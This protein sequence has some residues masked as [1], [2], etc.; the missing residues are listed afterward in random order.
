M[1]GVK[2]QQK[3]ES[4]KYSKNTDNSLKNKIQGVTDFYFLRMGL[5]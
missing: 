4:W 2:Q 5:A 1:G 3:S